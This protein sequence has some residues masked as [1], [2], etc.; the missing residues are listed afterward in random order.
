MYASAIFKCK[1]YRQTDVFAQFF[2][3]VIARSVYEPFL[4]FHRSYMT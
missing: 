2:A 1:Y 3:Q 4:T